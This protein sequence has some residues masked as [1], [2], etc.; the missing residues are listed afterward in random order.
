M[1]YTPTEPGAF[2]KRKGTHTEKLYD[3]FGAIKTE[4]DTYM[5]ISNPP[6]GSKKVTNLYVNEAG[7]TVVVT[8]T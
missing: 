6:A 4:L 7:E 5:V 2:R 1:T 8:A 3:E